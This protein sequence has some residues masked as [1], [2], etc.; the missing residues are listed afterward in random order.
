L[1]SSPYWPTGPQITSPQITGPQI[2]GL[3]ITG[4]QIT[5]PQIYDRRDDLVTSTIPARSGGVVH[6]G[7]VGI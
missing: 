4:P 6:H 1:G 3:Q 2:T 5:G 7:A